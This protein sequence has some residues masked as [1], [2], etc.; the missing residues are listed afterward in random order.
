MLGQLAAHIRRRY[1]EKEIEREGRDREKKRYSEKRQ[2]EINKQMTYREKKNTKVL[3]RHSFSET[4]KG[5]DSL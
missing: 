2:K 5:E 3:T 1:I 4:G